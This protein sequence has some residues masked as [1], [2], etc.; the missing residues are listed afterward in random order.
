MY[1]HQTKSGDKNAIFSPL[2][3]SDYLQ[4]FDSL[5]NLENME[6]LLIKGAERY[7][8]MTWQSGSQKWQWKNIGNE[9]IALVSMYLQWKVFFFFCILSSISVTLYSYFYHIKPVVAMYSSA[10]MTECWD[11]TEWPVC[12]HFI[13]SQLYFDRSPYLYFSSSIFVFFFI[14]ICI[15]SLKLY[16]W[17]SGQPAIT[18]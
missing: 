14:C 3:L 18:L 8:F 13:V 1:E 7:E 17:Q 2:F 16:I 6:S 15:L 5:Y 10:I 11:L 4:F 9:Y 12:N